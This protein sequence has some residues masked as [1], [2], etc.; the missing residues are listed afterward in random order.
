MARVRQK[1]TAPELAVRRLLYGAGFRYR[2]NTRSLPGSPDLVLPSRRLV[3]FVHGCFWHRHINCRRCTEPKT[4]R[5]F[6]TAKFVANV[7]RD[8][9]AQA[10][11]EAGGWRVRVVWECETRSQTHMEQ[12]L[13][14]VKA[15]P[16]RP[17]R[18]S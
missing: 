8:R 1:G 7:D 2:L 14:E 18:K 12:L 6:W 11:L 15:I 17:S 13:T 9:R 4:R 10:A 3:I 5:E 16:L